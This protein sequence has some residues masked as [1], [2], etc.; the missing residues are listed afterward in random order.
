MLDVEDST[1]SALTSDL[2]A[3]ANVFQ[4]TDDELLRVT[5]D[6]EIGRAGRD[7][8]DGNAEWDLTTTLDALPFQPPVI[9]RFRND[10]VFGGELFRSRLVLQ[11]SLS[12]LFSEPGDTFQTVVPLGI[13]SSGRELDLGNFLNPHDT[14]P[15]VNQ[16]ITIALQDQHIPFPA[17]SGGFDYIL[18][19]NVELD[20]DFLL[21]GDAGA[22][23]LN[24]TEGRD[25]IA[26]LGGSDILSGF[27]N[28]DR[29]FGG[30]GDDTLAG[31]PGQDGLHGGL[32]A[33]TAT[34]ESEESNIILFLASSRAANFLGD[35]DQLSSIENVV[36]TQFDDSIFGDDNPNVL[37]GG[38]GSDRIQGLGGGDEIHGGP[39]HEGRADIFHFFLEEVNGG[40]GN[41]KI[42]G[43]EGNDYLRGGHGD[44]TVDGGL[45]NDIIS[46]DNFIGGNQVLS[47]RDD[48]P[49]VFIFNRAFT[50]E[51]F[52]IGSAVGDDTLD[53][54][55]GD[56]AIGGG[57]G[58]DT[59]RGG[60]DHDQLFGGSGNDIIEGGAGNDYLEGG[61]ELGLDAF[62]S[63]SQNSR[64][65][66]NGVDFLATPVRNYE[67]GSSDDRDT[68]SGGAGDDILAGGQDSDMFRYVG[69]TGD[70]GE[71][72]VV[73]F[74]NGV[75]KLILD[76]QLSTAEFHG[77][78]GFSI[79]DESGNGT[80]GAEDDD[81]ISIEDRLYYDEARNLLTAS[82]T[83]INVG[84]LE[85]EV[86]G[87]QPAPGFNT[88]AVFN[89]TS[90]VQDDVLFLV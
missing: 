66:A 82:S 65:S 89:N 32:G 24:G 22:N 61:A 55:S 23:G 57:P 20:P 84:N 30:S 46:G 48:P 14:L 67:G 35:V 50:S 7:G 54:G 69:S 47:L 31:G 12:Q 4:V 64:W 44:D 39:G 10:N 76:L 77:R 42:F 53:G 33:D 73:D 41:D 78:T 29:L 17:I 34:F 13:L 27:G 83:V 79:L 6:L 71:D 86:L 5:V 60:E 85:R 49:E 37:N 87:R 8:L 74:E 43:E 72:L 51:V 18:H 2:R 25:L 16:R 15:R 80:L 63:L 68:L 56:D 62:V 11:V 70:Q 28:D 81:F 40:E 45:D 52:T 26:G 58:I 75:D 19:V 1:A 3:A 21:I 90:M 59:I 36:G 38:P 9:D 88:V